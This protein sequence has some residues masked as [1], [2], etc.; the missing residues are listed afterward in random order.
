MGGKDNRPD[1]ER[2]AD[3]SN[4]L[5]KSDDVLIPG[6]P[7]GHAEADGRKWKAKLS[8]SLV[9]SSEGGAGAPLIPMV[10]GCVDSKLSLCL[11][12]LSCTDVCVQM[13]KSAHY[14]QQH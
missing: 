2:P 6:G 9:E 12:L 1:T 13:I 10:S 14:L 7:Y 5:L 8:T 11:M 4:T 3:V